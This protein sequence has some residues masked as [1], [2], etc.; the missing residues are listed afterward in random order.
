MGILLSCH[1]C[2]EYLYKYIF[3]IIKFFLWDLKENIKIRV[4]NL[5]KSWDI[6]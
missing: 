1:T 5:N 4:L 3:L 2:P 6:Y